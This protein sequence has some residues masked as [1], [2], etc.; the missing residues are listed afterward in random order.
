MK[1]PGQILNVAIFAPVVPATNGGV[2][3]FILGLLHGLKNIDDG[4]DKCTIVANS[5][6][7]LELLRCCGGPNMRYVIRPLSANGQ[8]LPRSSDNSVI[9]EL[10]KSGLRPAVS[11][12]RRLL[13]FPDGQKSRRVPISDGFFEGLGCD[14]IHFPMQEEFVLCALPTIYN[15]HDLQHL[16]FPQFFSPEYIAW[17]ETIY[18]AGC[19][20][21]HTV[22]VGSQWIKDDIIRQYRINPEKIQVVPEGPP[23]QI[24][25]TSSEADIARVRLKYQLKQP[26]AFYPAFTWPHKNHIRLLESLA[27]L[28]DSR[29]M[30]IRLVCTGSQGRDSWQ[31]IARRIAELG[32]GSQVQFLG[33]VEEEDL[34]AIYRLA[35]F[36]VMPSLFEACSLPI[37]EA[38][39]VGLP[40]VCSNATALPDQVLDAAIMFDP[41]SIE[42]IADAIARVA[43]YPETRKT[44]RDRGFERVQE[45]N[46]RRTAKAYRAVYRR[47]ALVGLTDEDRCLL[48]WDWMKEPQGTRDDRC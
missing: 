35:Q 42:A 48:E 14:V 36:L 6:E 28:R 3:P 18:P 7:Q 12:V 19:H 45:F 20:F 46:W 13:A 40:V 26:F 38:W 11:A 30:T 34:A 33:Y 17:R 43:T 9:I 24:Y 32:L 25:T 39:W 15:P 8:I 27:F 29:G 31:R 10:V 41:Y 37:F 1:S 5:A 4:C 22:V 16:H 44:L 47:A 21:A 2:A 23:T